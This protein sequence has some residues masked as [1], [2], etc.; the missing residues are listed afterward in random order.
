MPLC[1]LPANYTY[2]Y[3]QI[4]S[5]IIPDWS[6]KDSKDG[7]NKSR[8]TPERTQRDQGDP[9]VMPKWPQRIPNKVT[10]KP[11][12]SDPKVNPKWH[13]IAP[14]VIPKLPKLTNNLTQHIFLET[15]WGGAHFIASLTFE[16]LAYKMIHLGSP[17]QE[18][19]KSFRIK[20][21]RRN[22]KIDIDGAPIPSSR[23]GPV[24]QKGC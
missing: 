14:E 13:Q 11:H 18:P 8:V 15:Q 12:Q 21:T 1:D 17:N 19:L 9:Q 4:S 5:Q 6:E 7:K 3:S 20:E 22:Q 24:G 10:P 23:G 16:T 2:K